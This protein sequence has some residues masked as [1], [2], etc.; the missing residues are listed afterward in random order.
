MQNIVLQIQT[1]SLRQSL[2]SKRSAAIYFFAEE[3]W[4]DAKQKGLTH[5]ESYKQIPIEILATELQEHTWKQEPPMG[6][7]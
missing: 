6:P 7:R 2:I 5:K 1:K 3:L 4:D